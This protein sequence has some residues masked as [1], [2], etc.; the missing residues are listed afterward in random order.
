MKKSFKI[1]QTNIV[2]HK[3]VLV[4]IKAKIQLHVACLIFRLYILNIESLLICYEWL[5]L[6]EI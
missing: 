2:N 1:F 5:S 4:F 3:R 6:C